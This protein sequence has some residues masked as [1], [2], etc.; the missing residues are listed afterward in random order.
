MTDRGFMYFHKKFSALSEL[1][2]FFVAVIV[3]FEVNFRPSSYCPAIQIFHLFKVIAFL[4]YLWSCQINQVFY[5]IDQQGVMLC[6]AAFEA[7]N[8][9][10]QFPNGLGVGCI[11]RLGRI[12][13]ICSICR[14]FPAEAPQRFHYQFPHLYRVVRVVPQAILQQQHIRQIHGYAVIGGSGHLQQVDDFF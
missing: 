6:A 14:H 1:N 9:R 3:A 12:P 8:Q 4:A 13:R 11:G 2:G 10:I 7:L 5:R